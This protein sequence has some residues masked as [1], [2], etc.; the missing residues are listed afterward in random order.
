LEGTLKIIWF[1]PPCH[2]QGHLPLDQVAQSYI[3]TGLEPFQGGG[4]PFHFLLSIPRK[5]SA[6]AQK[7]A[8]LSHLRFPL[9]GHVYK[10]HRTSFS[11]PRPALAIS[12]HCLY[13]NC[14][15]SAL[16]LIAVFVTF[17]LSHVRYTT[18]RV[19][20]RNRLQDIQSRNSAHT[21]PSATGACRSYQVFFPQNV[22][23]MTAQG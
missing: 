14:H 22:G 18:H 12:F 17:F 7:T 3:Q 9:K 2:E 19:L 8:T 16:L 21:A 10:S 11:L 4:I 23:I 5:H 15:P 13:L 20:F 6:Y 1:Q